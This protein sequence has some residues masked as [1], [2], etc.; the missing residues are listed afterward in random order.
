[1]KEKKIVF[2]ICSEGITDRVIM[3]SYNYIHELIIAH[4]GTTIVA[5]HKQ[6]ISMI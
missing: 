4:L 6:W 1:M 3:N 2:L 5:S